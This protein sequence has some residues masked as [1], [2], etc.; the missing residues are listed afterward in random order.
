MSLP[1]RSDI[2]FPARDHDDFNNRIPKLVNTTRGVIGP[3]PRFVV[4]EYL[5]GLRTI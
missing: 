1:I 3:I 4:G 5:S 2:L